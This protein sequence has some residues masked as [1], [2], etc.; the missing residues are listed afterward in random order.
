M[1]SSI[2]EVKGF[3][4]TNEI[5]KATQPEHKKLEEPSKQATESS[6]PKVASQFEEEKSSPACSEDPS[7]KANNNGV[8]NA[9]FSKTA[10]NI[11]SAASPLDSFI[12]SGG[13]QPVIMED[14]KDKE[15]NLKENNGNPET[16]QSIS[17][18]ND[19]IKL[20]N[21]TEATPIGVKRKRADSDESKISQP[22]KKGKVLPQPPLTSPSPCIRGRLDSVKE[23]AKTPIVVNGQSKPTVNPVTPSPAK[24]TAT[25]NKLLPLK[26]E[27]STAQLVCMNFKRTRFSIDLFVAK[28]DK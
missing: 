5:S 2:E 19:G 15:E 26:I 20:L 14:T 22:T 27:S 18:S 11:V 13:D 16:L 10:D 9:A 24:S 3:A 12:R 7:V 1:V 8:E 28:K 21:T 17:K 4:E 23:S 6:N 25:K